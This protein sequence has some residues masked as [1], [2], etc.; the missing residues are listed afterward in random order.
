[1]SALWW[2]FAGMATVKKS[3]YLDQGVYEEVRRLAVSEKRSV[4]AQIDVLIRR[5]LVSGAFTAEQVSSAAGVPQP[6]L[7]A[8][9]KREAKPDPKVKSPRRRSKARSA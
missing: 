1:M 9:L 7:V 5:A 6:V 4:T 3:I 2:Y 8:P